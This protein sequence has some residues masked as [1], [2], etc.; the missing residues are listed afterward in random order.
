MTEPRSCGDCGAKP[1]EPH[2]DGC[3]VAR[4]LWTGGQRLQCVGTLAA[5][6]CRTL[7][8]AGRTD[9]AEDLAHYLSLDDLNHDCGQEVWTGEWP[10]S[11][12]AAELGFFCI[13]GMVASGRPGWTVVDRDTPGAMPDLNRLCPPHARWDREQRKWVAP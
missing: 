9:L 6:A 10:G 5:E 11:A 7:I 4:C 13:W 3:D 12:D 1:G 8:G 2:D